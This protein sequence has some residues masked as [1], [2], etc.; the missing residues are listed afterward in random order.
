[1][2]YVNV[3]KREV[4]RFSKSPLGW[5]LSFGFPLIMCII[6]CLIFSKASPRALPVAVF[7]A[8]NSTLSRLVIKNVDTL[9]SC[10]IKYYIT[11]LQ[12]G[13]DLLVEGKIYAI[14]VIP[15]NFKRD[16][17]K[18]KQPKIVFYYNNQRLLI[19]GII[20]KDV[21]MM[22]RTM[23]IGIDARIKNTLGVPYATAIKNSNL[24]SI[25]E[26]AR[27]NP[28]FNYFYLLTLTV[29]GHIIQISM[30]MTSVWAIGTEF[31]FGKTK[32]WLKYADGSII[33]AILGKLT[34]Y[35][36][37][38]ATLFLLLFFVYFG[39]YRA[40]YLGN[41]LTGLLGTLFFILS[42][43][44]LGILFIS[45]NGNFRY[46]LSAAAFY[47]AI[48][49]ALA[50]IT[51]PTMAMP[52]EIKI[53]SATMPLTYWAQIMLDQSIRKIPSIYDIKFFIPFICV[54]ILAAIALFRLKKLALDENRWYQS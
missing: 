42:A 46:C 22:I 24:I 12:Q 30:V 27:S 9:P 13:K 52:I 41:I 36:I 53:Y 8:D 18:A 34:P 7:D 25:E 29:F 1:M 5:I 54:I 11:D 23:Q 10:K 44:S 6:V 47:V 16:M 14:L 50:G 33:I 19:S 39:F 38:F 40:P 20:S 2:A 4:S 51:F 37:I 17:F 28:Y 45:I 21:M 48:G 31:K 35:L 3:V 43:L 49:F 32:E 26:H 15:K